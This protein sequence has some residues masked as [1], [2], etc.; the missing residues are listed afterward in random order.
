MTI[1]ARTPMSFLL[2]LRRTWMS[3]KKNKVKN[4]CLLREQHL[5]FVIN[6]KKSVLEPWQ[7]MEFLGLIVDS[8]D[9]SLA[10]TK[11]KLQKVMV[12]CVEMHEAITI[13]ILELT[14]LIGLL[15]STVQAVLPAQQFRYMQNLKIKAL[16][17]HLCYQ[18]QVVLG[19]RCR[20]QTGAKMVDSEP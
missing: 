3:L 13:S 7:R 15:C 4:E 9:R 5:G 8:R 12:S 14:K 1:M 6:L 19:F 2:E 17:Q 20:V 18:Q 16:K 10:L 11:E